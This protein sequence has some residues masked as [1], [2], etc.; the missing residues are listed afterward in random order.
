MAPR[1][2]LA[3]ALAPIL[4]C[5]GEDPSPADVVEVVP[6]P[7]TRVLSA[8]ALAA[9]QAESGSG[10]LVFSP[11]P[12]GLT[13]EVGDVLVAGLSDSTPSGLLRLV[14]AVQ[15]EGTALTVETVDAP[16]QLAF[17]RVHVRAQRDTGELGDATWSAAKGVGLRR[18]P[19]LDLTSG[20]AHT[21]Q[22]LTVLLFDGDGDP[23]TEGDQIA[24][25]GELGGGLQY[26]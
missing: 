14:T 7:S 22:H 1:A 19:L 13:L 17:R 10:R 23:T 16:L 11:P 9:L 21:T 4:A 3:L 6:F 25:D 12:A 15:A 20:S 8:D 26:R 18:Q 24:F 5:G 2:L